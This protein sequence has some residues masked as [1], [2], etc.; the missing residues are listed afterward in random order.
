MTAS[1]F[2]EHTSSTS[3]SAGH[4]SARKLSANSDMRTH[5]SARVAIL[6]RARL[7]SASSRYT[8][9][10][11]TSMM[12]G[13]ASPR[14]LIFSTSSE[15][16]TKGGSPCFARSFTTSGDE[17]KSQWSGVEGGVR[18]ERRGTGREAMAS[19][20]RQMSSCA[21]RDGA[22]RAMRV[23]RTSEEQLPRARAAPLFA[24]HERLQR[25]FHR[26]THGTRGPAR[27]REVNV[28]GR[29][30]ASFEFFFSRDDTI[31]CFLGDIFL[32]NNQSTRPPA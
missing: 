15:K 7:V 10:A 9:F 21:E 17:R 18:R 8:A 25:L 16:S 24:P 20:G 2:L 12:R 32:E 22:E 27:A 30:T 4:T 11:A 19:D 13:T 5:E 6:R 26:E 14:L 23:G 28:N 31:F 29:E 3:Y 1:I